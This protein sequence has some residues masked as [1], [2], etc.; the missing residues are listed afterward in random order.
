MILLLTYQSFFS[1]LTVY[2]VSFG[3][4][5]TA[6]DEGDVGVEIVELDVPTITLDPFSKHLV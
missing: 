5:A 4:L 3:R 6:V 1:D 2:N